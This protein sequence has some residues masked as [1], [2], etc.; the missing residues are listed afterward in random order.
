MAFVKNI[1][2]LFTLDVHPVP[3]IGEYVLAASSELR[4]RGISA[5]F[6]CTAS[7]LEANRDVARRV[8]DEGHEIGSHG[9]LHN[10][11][12]NWGFPPERYDL[13]P[14]RDQRYYIEE[15]THRAWVAL[16]REVRVFRAPCFGISGATVRLLQE[17]GYAAD[18]SVNSQRL[19]LLTA[20]PF[21]CNNLLA[22]RLPYHPSVR[23]PYRRGNSMLLEI[24]LSSFVVP[25]AAMTLLVFGP[26]ATKALLRLL[27]KEA[28]RSGKPIVY[29]GHPE[30]FCPDASTYA[31]D[32][33]S[34][35]WKDYFPRQSC[36]IRA[37]QALLSNDPAKNFRWNRA[38][39]DNL[40]SFE[41]DFVTATDYLAQRSVAEL[42]GSLA[43]SA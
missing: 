26:A 31:L 29:M 8:L 20:R 40:G 11:R 16:G 23:N 10:D 37:R 5:T 12:R 13:L 39:L 21:S 25:F 36:G 15:A 34:L 33:R 38:L 6:L 9:L 7:V 28:R 18:L 24:P 19:D 14:E 4:D 3:R 32:R 17:H 27:H 41:L 2:F 42:T 22:P 1:P 43:P 35:C 30:E